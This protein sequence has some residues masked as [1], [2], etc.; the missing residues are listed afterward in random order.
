MSNVYIF[1]STGGQVHQLRQV[2]LRD[3]QVS[4]QYKGMFGTP[5]LLAL[6]Y[7]KRDIRAEIA[8]HSVILVQNLICCKWDFIM[9]T[10][11]KVGLYLNSYAISE[12]TPPFI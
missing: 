2:R 11:L 4:L 8:L 1:Q 3:P 7:M 9:I 12:R 5:G 6:A 10:S